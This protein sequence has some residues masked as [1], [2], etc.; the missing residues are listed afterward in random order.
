VP[1]LLVSESRKGEEKYWSIRLSYPKSTSFP[2]PFYARNKQRN[3]LLKGKAEIILNA[4]K[5]K[6]SCRLILHPNP[7]PSS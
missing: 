5:E 1:V 7:S 4:L 6:K 2:R 3:F